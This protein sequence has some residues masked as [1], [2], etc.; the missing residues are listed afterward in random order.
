MNKCVFLDRDGVLNE[1]IG[2]Y[3]WQI[4]DF[5]IRPGVI[6]LLKYF[7]SK[8]YLL[9]VITNQGGIARGL[10]THEDV[11]NCHNHFQ[12]E[13][14]DLIDDFYYSPYQISF[15]ASLGFK[16]GTLL[17]EK[18]IA[19]YAIDSANSWMIG[20]KERDITP[21]K[22]L[23]IKTILLL[24]EEHSGMDSGADFKV[25]KLEEIKSIIK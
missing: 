4:S 19:K 25:K 9:I 1:E 14:G 16:P 11:K 17:F 5:V 7:K 21:A 23:K 12:S 24:S 18:A 6:D 10:Y 2:R 3:V 13:C 22:K 8:G 15:S 20:D